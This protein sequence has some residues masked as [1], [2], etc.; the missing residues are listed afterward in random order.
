MR[1]EIFMP[2]L[3]NILRVCKDK[4]CDSWDR[5]YDNATMASYDVSS[6]NSR[7]LSAGICNN[8]QMSLL[9]IFHLWNKIISFHT[10]I[11]NVYIQIYIY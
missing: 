6:V 1:Y 9:C 4:Q 11:E 5:Y 3:W 10:L 8:D 2:E 7:T